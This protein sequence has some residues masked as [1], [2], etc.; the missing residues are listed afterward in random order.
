IHFADGSTRAPGLDLSIDQ[1]D[2]TPGARIQCWGDS[3]T[4]GN[5]DGTGTSF[6]DELATLTG[7]LIFNRG[8]GGQ[9]SK[10]IAMRQGGNVARVTVTGNTISSGANTITHIDAVELS[11][12]GGMAADKDQPFPLSSQ[13]NNTTI[14]ARV[15]IQGVSGT[16]RRSA[17]GGPPSTSESY[18]FTPDAD[19]TLPANC[20][21]QSPMLFLTEELQGDISIL[22]LGRNDQTETDQIKDGIAACVSRIE[23]KG[24]R[25]LVL[26]VLTGDYDPEEYGPSG[27]RYLTTVGLNNDLEALYTDRY[28]D[29]RRLLITE[30]LPRAGITPT[31]QDTIDIGNDVP[32]DSL[33]HDAI[34]LNA[35][36]YGVVAQLINEKL[37]ALGWIPGWVTAA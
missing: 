27:S 29:V 22:W 24:G 33:R 18:T 2:V 34:H 28:L 15:R 10:Q 5:Q 26:S 14:A 3:L 35:A 4:F 1:P 17:A 16:L 36:G 19:A 8:I 37:R 21:A 6:P 11:T 25:Y 23:R 31:A 32:P 30:G 20:P 12:S 13:G 7:I 9:T